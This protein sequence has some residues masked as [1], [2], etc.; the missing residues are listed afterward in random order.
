MIFFLEPVQYLTEG[1]IAALKPNSKCSHTSKY[2]ALFRSILPCIASLD[3]DFEQV[4]TCGV[5]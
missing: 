1:R 2:A 3:R 4:L 5:K